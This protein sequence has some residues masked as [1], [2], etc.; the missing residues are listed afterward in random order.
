VKHFSTDLPFL[1]EIQFQAQ[2]KEVHLTPLED[3]FIALLLAFLA[4]T[5]PFHEVFVNHTWTNFAGKS[6]GK[7]ISKRYAEAV[8]TRLHSTEAFS[9]PKLE[10]TQTLLMLGLHEWRSTQGARGFLTIG[11]AVRSAMMQRLNIQEDLQ[12]GEQVG[13]RRQL[14]VNNSHMAPEE[15]YIDEEKRRRTF[16]S[17]YI[18]DSYVSSG[19]DRPWS[20][21]N[22]T[23]KVQLPCSDPAFI[24]GMNVR[25]RMLREGDIEFSNRKE[26]QKSRQSGQQSNMTNGGGQVHWEDEGGNLGLSWFIRVLCEWRDV[27][28]WTCNVTRRY[29]APLS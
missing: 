2:L 5:I 16:W 17:C 21:Q 7:A 18:M 11:S 3:P 28:H 4:L 1:H 13:T 25:T 8:R 24:Y 14:L 15:R 29:A 26:H 22:D 6:S 19:K 10:T 27:V 23:I 12:T 9:L 20:I